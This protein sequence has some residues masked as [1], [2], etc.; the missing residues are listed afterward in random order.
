MLKYFRKT[1]MNRKGFTFIELMIVVVI[2]GVLSGIAIMTYGGESKDKAKVAKVKADLRIIESAY[3]INKIEKESAPADIA[4]LVTN[5]YL[6]KK[7]SSPVAGY[8]YMISGTDIV[9]AATSDV[10]DVYE[11]DLSD[12]AYDFICN[13]A[14]L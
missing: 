11:F 10:T 14:N 6:K 12:E 9:L 4:A 8:S 1:L 13:S 7:P 2:L 3:S 5:G